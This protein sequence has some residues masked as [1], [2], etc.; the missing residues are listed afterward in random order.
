M[1]E[2]RTVDVRLAGGSVEQ[3]RLAEDVA[4]AEHGAAR[5]PGDVDVDLTL[6]D[7]EERVGRL[8][9]LHHDGARGQLD[10]VGAVRERAQ[11]VGRQLREE[12]EARHEREAVEAGLF[13]LVRVDE[14]ELGDVELDEVLLEPDLLEADLVV[15]LIGGG[16]ED[17]RAHDQALA[18]SIGAHRGGPH[19]AVLLPRCA[20]VDRL[21]HVRAGGIEAQHRLGHRDRA[22]HEPLLRVEVGGLLERVRGRLR[23]AAASEHLAEL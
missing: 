18:T 17:R 22:R 20:R 11:L 5:E 8:P 3:A 4:L 13:R 9:A 6:D 23:L 14:L 16:R 12:R 1:S 2:R 19:L 21:E 15:A 10:E 7:A